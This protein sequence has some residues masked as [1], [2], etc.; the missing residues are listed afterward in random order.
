[1][2]TE[3][4]EK[5][6]HHILDIHS[7]INNLHKTVNDLNNKMDTMYIELKAGQEELNKRVSNLELGQKELRA[8]LEEVQEDLL[9]VHQANLETRD[10]FSRKT[11]I[12]I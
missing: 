1:M 4:E 7:D 6:L 9:T 12:Q 11:G 2:S 5:L 3:F 8:I 10:I